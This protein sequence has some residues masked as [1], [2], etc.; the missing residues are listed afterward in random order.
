MKDVNSIRRNLRNKANKEKAQVLQRFFKTGKGEYGEGDVFLGVMVP[1]SRRIAKEY[2]GIGL[3]DLSF[4]L[5]SKIHEERLVALLIL[6]DKF[7]RGSDCERKEVVDFYLNNLKWINNWDL[8]DLSAYK[9]LG[10]Y[11]FDKEKI[12]LYDLANSTNVWERRIA[13]V[14]TFY[15]I[16]NNYFTDTLLISEMLLEDEHNLIHKAVGWMLREVGKRGLKQE[17]DFIL[18]NYKKIHRTTLRYAIERF[19]KNKKRY[20]LNKNNF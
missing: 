13:I 15:F 6:V 3:R 18:K 14:A 12:I 16:R 7:E 10:R 11:C 1:D 8:V 20:Y 9:I 4:L 5:H 2:S 17:E 19:E